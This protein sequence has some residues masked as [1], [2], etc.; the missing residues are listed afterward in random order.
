MSDRRHAADG[1]AG[2]GAHQIGIGLAERLAR[3]PARLL[4]ADA[5]AAGGEEQHDVPRRLA[6]EDDRL[7]DLVKHATRRAGRLFGGAR[8]PRH[9]E[10]LRVLARRRKRRRH[11]LQALAHPGLR[12]L[13]CRVKPRRAAKRKADD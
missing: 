8:L 1:K 12:I 10:D 2:L 7:G 5:V 11:P 6:A 9:L 4:G 13:H 3:H